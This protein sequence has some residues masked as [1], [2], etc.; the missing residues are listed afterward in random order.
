MDALKD[1]HMD[2]TC[3]CFTTVE[4]D[5][6]G[7]ELAEAPGS[8]REIFSTNARQLSDRL[9]SFAGQIQCKYLQD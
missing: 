2:R 7:W 4:A 6:K 8:L 1:L 9:L 5:G 3:I